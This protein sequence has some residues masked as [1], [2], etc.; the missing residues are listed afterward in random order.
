LGAD[1]YI[2]RLEGKIRECLFFY[3]KIFLINSVSGDLSVFGSSPFYLS[4]RLLND[5]FN[6]GSLWLLQHWVPD[7]VC[8]IR[9]ENDLWRASETR[10]P[11][12]LNVIVH[13]PSSS[14]PFYLGTR[15]PSK[16]HLLWLSVPQER[17]QNNAKNKCCQEMTD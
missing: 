3:V 11:R 4:L 13:T 12:D 7:G 2:E 1:E 15:K 16:N 9:H 14:S 10:F 8:G 6:F 5:I 17:K